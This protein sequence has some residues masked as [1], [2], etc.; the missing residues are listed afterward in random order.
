MAQNTKRDKLWI[1][2]LKATHR[3]DEA[4]TAEDLALR[5]GTSEKSARDALITMS[6]MNVVRVDKNGREVRYLADETLFDPDAML[7]QS[8][9]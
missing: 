9:I 3:N 4:I 8:H 2:A 6:N 7:D 5:A 1:F